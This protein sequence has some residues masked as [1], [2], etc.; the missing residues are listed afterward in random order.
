MSNS[1]DVVVLSTS[2]MRT[3]RVSQETF[4]VYLDACLYLNSYLISEVLTEMHAPSSAATTCSLQS[5]SI[6]SD[7]R[8]RYIWNVT[9]TWTE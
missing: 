7:G 4:D 3:A 9:A 2:Y 1:L 6:L 8:R 5:V